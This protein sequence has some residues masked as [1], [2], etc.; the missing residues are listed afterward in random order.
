M[1]PLLGP[2]GPAR[3]LPPAWGLWFASRR[4]PQRGARPRTPTLLGYVFLLDTT[5]HSGQRPARGFYN[6]FEMCTHISGMFCPLLRRNVL[7]VAY[8][9]AESLR[10]CNECLRINFTSV[11]ILSHVV[12]P[13]VQ[14]ASLARETVTVTGR[15]YMVRFPGDLNAGVGRKHR[16]LL[17]TIQ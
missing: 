3:Q 4:R 8:V 11:H 16:S 13:S 6:A 15:G 9:Q 7:V 5:L 2:P 17:V 12:D 1:H 14:P 10:M